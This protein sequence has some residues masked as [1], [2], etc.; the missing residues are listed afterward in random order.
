MR[1]RLILQS[2]TDTVDSYGQSIRSWTTYTTVWGQVIA[3]GGTEVQQAAQLSGL[4]T[5]QITIR[6]LYTVIM[7]HRMIW[8]NKT[9]NIQSVIPLDGERKFIRIVAIEEQ[10]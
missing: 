3:L 2:P 5:Y 6:T 4:V 8:Q 7:T 10:P 1:H 9:L